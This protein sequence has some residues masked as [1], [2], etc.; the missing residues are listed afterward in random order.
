MYCA[1]N[2]CAMNICVRN[3]L[4]FSKRFPKRCITMLFLVIGIALQSYSQDYDNL[5]YFYSGSYKTFIGSVENDYS[6]LEV[7]GK[8]MVQK[9][10]SVS[11]T[12]FE[13]ILR[14]Q[15]PNS[16]IEWFDDDM[17]TVVTRENL[18]K[19]AIYH[20]LKEK[21]V[22]SAT[23]KYTD[24][25]VKGSEWGYSNVLEAKF[26]DNVS[27]EIQDKTLGKYNTVID[28]DDQIWKQIHCFFFSVDKWLDVF[29]VSKELYETGLFQFV[30]P[31]VYS[32]SVKF[33]M[34]PVYP[35]DTYFSY[36][37]ALHNTGQVVNG[38]AGTTD[39]DID[40][41]E[42]W[43]ITMGSP[44]V[45]V[46]VIDDGV[47]SNHPDLP[48]SRQLRLPG[49]NFGS[50]DPN[51]PSPHGNDN[52]GNSCAGVIAASIN[53]NEG[54]V[55]VAPYCTIMPIRWEANS[56]WPRRIAAFNFAVQNGANIISIS[57]GFT[58]QPMSNE[59]C[60][61]C[62]IE[63]AINQG[64]VVVMAAGNTAKH[65]VDNDGFLRYPVDTYMPD[66][67]V[68]GASDRDDFQADYSPTNPL[69]NIVA[70]SHKMYLFDTSTD[71]TDY[72]ILDIW[73]IDQP[74]NSG[75]NPWPVGE[76]GGIANGEILP[77]SG[78]NYLAYT[79]HF[80]GT[81]HACPV[82]AG[83]AAL[84][85]SEYPWLTPHDIY[86]IITS[87]A[88]KIGPYDYSIDGRCPQTGYGRVNAFKALNSICLSTYINEEIN[89]DKNVSS[90]E[91]TIDDTDIRDSSSLSVNHRKFTQI[92]GMSSVETGG[93][94]YIK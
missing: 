3:I 26:K 70:P 74:G 42:A 31:T 12:T 29:A 14:K 18:V 53:N 49:S 22:I 25:L 11:K 85:L 19:D 15:V 65:R 54:I 93:K 7:P 23:R 45:V 47:S 43:S 44:D 91:V 55:G 37:R 66:V 94:L 51:D 5:P 6:I 13:D 58:N 57:C 90:C 67:L 34:R 81:S 33:D 35:N 64:V 4:G 86:T 78:P 30:Y 9:D 84:L 69:I 73:T 88:D 52:H 89:Y 41:P 80:G 24:P 62:A 27:E 50:G 87:T 77:N 60:L 48:N 75:H 38:R 82:V 8:I 17:C 76:G 63:S 71:T 68:V 1:D 83:V 32:E 36:Q 39:A 46:A 21:V 10:M 20:L 72:E 40:A 16:E 61:R 92:N 79:S 59:G 28:R 2:K 56:S